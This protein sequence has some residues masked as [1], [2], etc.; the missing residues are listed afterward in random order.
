MISRASTSFAIQ[1]LLQFLPANWLV[2]YMGS[3]DILSLFTSKFCAIVFHILCS[4]ISFSSFNY[5]FHHPSQIISLWR[6]L[7]PVCRI[8]VYFSRTK[9]WRT[10]N[11]LIAHLSGGFRLGSAGRAGSRGLHANEPARLSPL[12]YSVLITN[13]LKDLAPKRYKLTTRLNCPSSRCHAALHSKK[14]RLQTRPDRYPRLIV[15]SMTLNW[16]LEMKVARS[17]YSSLSRTR[18]DLIFGFF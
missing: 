14:V 2:G 6:D 11:N 1:F 13:V 18:S 7:H 5:L 12:C 16:Q 15:Y 17:S 3:I 9:G 8:E 10:W 4:S